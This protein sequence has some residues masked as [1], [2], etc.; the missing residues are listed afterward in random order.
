MLDEY[1]EEQKIAYKVLK[2]AVLKDKCAHAYLIETNGYIKKE[3]FALS[4][5][6]YILCPNKYS[7]SQKCVNCTQCQNIDKNIFSEVKIIRPEK[8]SLWIKKEQLIELQEEFMTKSL[9][10]NKKIYII[11]DATKLNTSS[12]NSILKFLE[13]PADNIIA[14]LLADNIHQLLD[15]IVSRCQIISLVNKKTKENMLESLISVK[16]ENIE[17]IKESTINYINELEKNKKEMILYNKKYFHNNIKEKNEIIVSFEIMILY[18]KD[19]IN[20]KLN[21]KPE[22]IENIDNILMNNTIDK[23]NEK[24]KIITNLKKNIYVNANTNLLMDKLVIEL[25]GV[26]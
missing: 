18:Y 2:N 14:I 16:I 19:A 13:E 26:Q 9:L 21:R 6:K 11:T 10:A 25:G 8:D 12:A 24:I 3:E 5:A 17:E 4:I 7:N 20:L 15:T 23:L 1:K 22:V